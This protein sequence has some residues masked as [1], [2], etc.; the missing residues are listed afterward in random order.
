MEKLQICSQN[1]HRKHLNHNKVSKLVKQN[2]VI[3]AQEIYLPDDRK[4]RENELK[5]LSKIWKSKIYISSKVKGAHI[6]TIIKEKF[7]TNIIDFIELIE[8]R[9]TRLHIKNEEYEYFI[10]NIYAPSN[11]QKDHVIFCHKLFKAVKFIKYVIML[12]DW[13]SVLTNDMCN[14][15]K[16]EHHK[17]QSK[18]IE[19]FFQNWIDV[20]KI[21]TTNIKYTYTNHGYRA[22]LD[23]V[24]IKDSNLH[25]ITDY[26]IEPST[27]SDHDQI[28]IK[29]KWGKRPV[30]GRRLWKM[31]IEILSDKEYRKRIENDIEIFK[32]NKTFYDPM[33]SWDLL[34][35]KIK[36]TTIEYTRQ[37]HTERKDEVATLTQKHADIVAKIDNSE[38]DEELIEQKESLEQK[39]EQLETKRTEGDRIRAKMEKIEYDERSTKYYF[40]KEKEKGQR[41]QIVILE[42]EQDETLET[43]HEIMGEIEKF[44]TEL[45]TTESINIEQMNENLHYIKNKLTD[46]DQKEINDF[47]KTKEISNAI[48]EMKNEKSPGEDGIPKEFYLSFFDEL[49][50][51][52]TELFNNIKFSKTQPH[53]HKNAIIKLI[54]KKNNQKHLKNWRPISLLNVDYKILSKILTKRLT[55]VIDKIVPIEQKCGVKDR[56]MTDII[57]NIATYRDYSY[58]GYLILIDQT[59]A[60][61]RVNHEYLY[62]TLEKLGINGDFLELTKML[63]KEITSQIEVNGKRTNKI[64]IQRG[65][66]QGCPYSMLLF[67]LSTIPLLEMIKQSPIIKGH[68]TKL[69][70]RIKVQAYA[71]DTTVLIQSPHELNE[72]NRIFNKHSKASEAKINEEKTQIF[73]LSQSPIE[74][75]PKE[76]K[77][78]LKSEVTILGSKF[79]T[80]KSNETKANIEKAMKKLM[81]WNETFNDYT[82]LVGKILNINTYIYTT[83]FNSAWLLDTKSNAFNNL[84]TEIS[85][86]LQKIKSMETYELVAKRIEEGGLNLIN[87]KERIETLKAIEI[88]EAAEKT[89]E[90]DNIIF[91]TSIHQTKLYTKKLTGPKCESP[92]KKLLE[93]IK[94]LEP[95]MELIRNYKKRHKKLTTKALQA[96]IFQREKVKNYREI[97]LAREPKLISINYK[98]KY[99]LLPVESY[100]RCHFC[101]SSEETITHIMVECSFFINL[102]RQVDIWLK[103]IDKQKLNKDKIINMIGLEDEVENQIITRYKNAI[104][105]SR[106]FT[107]KTKHRQN[108]NDIIQILDKDIRFYIQYIHREN[109][110]T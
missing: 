44:Y 34:K 54:Y 98:V 84:I 103:A 66:R 82:S 26:K 37:K 72:V 5:Y 93:I 105:K 19:H 25:S 55:K 12:G 11:N 99:G 48:R 2:D 39:I 96:I 83:I 21:I 95:N 87:I 77:E 29:T 76:L 64:Q 109:I 110:S 53:S 43:E 81:K 90:T 59:K 7:E 8:G 24:Y 32:L 31:N 14:K 40:K 108:I 38:S 4:E 28:K 58:N 71:D 102:R 1:F 88:L 27:F 70:N 16:N 86:Y 60:F 49:K 94:K 50:E 36:Q 22:R 6:A 10:V 3:L 30:W 89:P 80:D 18:L 51:I 101:I 107:K 9:A 52:L 63:Y 78:K 13:N 69:N 45:Y 46:Q 20:H 104:W 42:N 97:L 62:K 17:R 73:R 56:K 15:G 23:R 61:D 41:K 35:S 47:I 92:P 74:Y 67:I 85:K 91:E 65:V 106:N 79:C 57:R 33:E 75:E 100:R 68:R